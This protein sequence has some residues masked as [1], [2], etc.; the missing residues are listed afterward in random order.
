MQTKSDKDASI[1][2]GPVQTRFNNAPAPIRIEADA[3]R[4]RCR[5]RF[6]IEHRAALVRTHARFRS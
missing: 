3:G 2:I 4:I 5:S 1:G 6:Q